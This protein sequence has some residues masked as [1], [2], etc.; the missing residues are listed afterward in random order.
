MSRKPFY[1]TTPIYYVNDVPHIGH[2]YTTIAADVMTR[3]RRMCGFDTF[4]LTGTDEHGQK[5]QRAAAAKGLTAQELADRT[6]VNFQELWKALGVSNDDFIRTTEERHRKV[7]QYIFATLLAKGDIYK[8]SYEG[9][10]CVPCETYVPESQMGEERTCP[11]CGRKL[12]MMTEES[13]FFRMSRYAEPLLAYYEANGE[14]ILPK[15]RYNEI[16]SFLRGGLRD[17]SISRTTISWGIPVPGDEKHV[18]YVWFDAL[19]NYLAAVGYPEENAPWK[20]YWPVVHHLVGKDIIRFHSVVWPA[21]LLALGVNPPKLVFAHGWWTVE[22]EKMSKSKGNVVDPFEM[23]ELYGRDS[24][25]YFLLREVP[26]GL[27]GDFSELALVQRRNADLANDL[28]NL[29]NRTLQMVERYCGGTIPAA[30]TETELERDLVE[31]VAATRRDVDSCM[32]RYAFDEALKSIWILVGRGNKYIDDTMPWK[33]GKEENTERL[34]TVLNTLCRVLRTVA[35]L[36]APFIPDSAARMVDQLGLDAE[37][38]ARGEGIPE[39]TEDLSGVSVHRGD[40]LFPR[41]DL[42]EWEAAKAEREARKGMLPDPGDH[43]PEIEVEQFR[44]CEFRVASVLAVEPVPKADKLYKLE[45]DLG[46]ER[47]TIV[48]GIREFYAPE[49]LVGRKIIVL[50]NLKPAKLRGVVSNGMLLAAETADGKG[51]ALLTVDRDIAPG[52]R[53]H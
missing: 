2:A 27:D 12:E 9:W 52:S 31:L 32:D 11:D 29:L 41:I 46:Y 5:I 10:Y 26:F 8:G 21:M 6:V 36:V 44:N 37:I 40:I 7:V 15:G 16:L 35:Y 50:C 30:G 43:E 28:G 53:I 38:I 1:V 33:L 39:W 19:I 23:V 18:V 17:Q 13:Y 25:R 48:S 3:Y 49:E 42:K 51:L 24:F 34:G 4:F 45:L 20:K 14:A 47:R 22:G